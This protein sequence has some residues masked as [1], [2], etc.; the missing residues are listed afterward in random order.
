MTTVGVFAAILDRDNRILCVKR[1][2]GDQAWTLPGGR[3]EAGEA[4]DDAFH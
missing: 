2:Y 3:V 1:A 4:L